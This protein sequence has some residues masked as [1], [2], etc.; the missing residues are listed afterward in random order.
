MVLLVHGGPWWRSMYDFNAPHQWLANRGYA[1][2]DVNFRGSTGFGKAFVNAGDREWG[3]KMHDDLVDAVQWAIA[4]GVAHPRRVAIMGG[5]Y[6]GYATL[7]G[8]TFT[9]DLFC[10]GVDRVGP[11]D[12]ESLLATS[13]PH[14]ASFYEEEC[15]RIGDPR[16]EEG[17][18]LLRD[19]SPLH[20]VQ[21]IKKPLLIGQGANDIRVNQAE[22]DQ[23]VAAMKANGLDVT[24]LL[25]PDE[26]HGLERP[27]N[28]LAWLAVVETFLATHLGGRAEAI[29]DEFATTCVEVREGADHIA[30]LSEALAAR[31]AARPMA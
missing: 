31:Q 29:G 17:R 7:V 11:S 13:P 10:C 28:R 15:R 14:W 18:A 6:G 21:S 16:T 25:H 12:L 30:G 2:L 22:S 26:G 20:R 4:E 8:M 23:I 9:P 5:S 1:V 24:Y 27:E 3:G 19:R